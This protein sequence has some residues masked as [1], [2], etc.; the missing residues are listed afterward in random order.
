MHL[1]SLMRD[2][3]GIP[4]GSVDRRSNQGGHRA[5][6]DANYVSSSRSRLTCINWDKD[7]SR[8]SSQE[9]L[10]SKKTA[11]KARPFALVPSCLVVKR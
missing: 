5:L 1:I 11:R 6:I 8:K 2:S 7:A 3:I 9:S 10:T 4:R